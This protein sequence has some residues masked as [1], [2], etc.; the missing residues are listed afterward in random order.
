MVTSESCVSV[1]GGRVV[2]QW[3]RSEQEERKWR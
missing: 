2:V 3:V 1:V